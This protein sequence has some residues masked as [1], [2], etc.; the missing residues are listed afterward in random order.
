MQILGLG[1]MT[2]LTF[3]GLFPLFLKFSIC[4]FPDRNVVHAVCTMNINMIFYIWIRLTV[5]WISFITND[6]TP[7]AYSSTASQWW[8]GWR[9]IYWH[10]V[11]E[12]IS[13]SVTNSFLSTILKNNGKILQIFYRRTNQ[14]NAM[15]LQ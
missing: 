11:Q 1:H 12:F 6:F 9:G 2:I 8:E 15:W 3:W 10:N 5:H 7:F 4:Y 13:P 14:G